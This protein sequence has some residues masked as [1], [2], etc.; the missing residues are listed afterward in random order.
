MGGGTE[1][2]PNLGAHCEHEDCNQLDFL[3]FTCDG[4]QKTLCLEHRTYKSHNCP[5]S[6]LHSRTVII[7]ETCS[8]S[9]EKKF[10]ED[11]KLVFEIHAKSGNC[12]PAKKQKP[13]CPVKRCKEVLT[14][15]NCSSCKYCSLKVCLKHRFPTD[16]LC[17]GGI[18]VSERNGELRSSAIAIKAY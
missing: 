13:K 3:P 10:G 14:F 7:C 1:A 15:S 16:H 18:R 12:N 4:C 11:E 2:F 9:M 6:E 5:K 17:K 8:M